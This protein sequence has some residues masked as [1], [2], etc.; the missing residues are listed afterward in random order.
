MRLRLGIWALVVA[1][2]VLATR[3]I[4]YALAPQ[5]VLLAALAHNQA[6]A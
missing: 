6:R 3:T 5:S 1:A 4:V 2:V